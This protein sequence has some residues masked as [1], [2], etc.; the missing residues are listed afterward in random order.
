MSV[1]FILIA[2]ARINGGNALKTYDLTVS[3]G[4][5]APD[6]ELRDV[7]LINGELGGPLIVVDQNEQLNI[8]F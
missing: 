1:L 4:R 2:L 7:I 5:A 8:P 6:G 3:N